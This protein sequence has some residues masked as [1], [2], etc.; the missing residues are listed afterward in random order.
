MQKILTL[1]VHNSVE[2]V[3]I[4]CGNLFAKKFSPTFKQVYSPFF[5]SFKQSGI[6]VYFGMI[7]VYRK[8]G[9]IKKRG[10]SAANAS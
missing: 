5:E 6:F 2:N 1:L 4:V 8:I 9:L 7:F 3:L 10:E